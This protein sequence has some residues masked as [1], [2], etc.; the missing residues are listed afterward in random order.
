[1]TPIE[2]MLVAEAERLSARDEM[3]CAF[4][5]ERAVRA[6]K[7]S[8]LRCIRPSEDVLLI[9]SMPLIASTRIACFCEDSR[10]VFCRSEEH[11]SELQSLM[12]TSYA[13]FCLKKKKKQQILISIVSSLLNTTTTQ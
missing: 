4:I 6:T 10:D 9:V 7:F 1:M 11:T 5:A 3:D 8:Q 2:T 12:R 13:V